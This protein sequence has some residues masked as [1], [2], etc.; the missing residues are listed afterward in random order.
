MFDQVTEIL[1]TKVVKSC[2]DWIVKLETVR[3]QQDS[4]ELLA[5]AERVKHY[6]DKIAKT[7][8][9]KSIARQQEKLATAAA[10]YDAII[11]PISREMTT[12]LVPA[13]GFLCV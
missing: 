9:A 11:A 8:D 4:K 12:V 7:K 6:E 2:D 13:I 1:R 10:D 3:G 5:A